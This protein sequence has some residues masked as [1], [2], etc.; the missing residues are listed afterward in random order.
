VPPSGYKQIVSAARDQALENPFKLAIYP[1]PIRENAMQ[2]VVN[3]EKQT[4]L[5]IEILTIWGA[6]IWKSQQNAQGIG[7]Q[8]LH[9]NL[10]NLMQGTYFLKITSNG[11]ME[12]KKFVVVK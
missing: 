4:P 5:Q 12:S 7:N 11:K 1:N 10:P 6:S 9:L 2:V 8:L 3:L